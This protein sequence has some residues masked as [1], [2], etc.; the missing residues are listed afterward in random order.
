M[1]NRT[2]L[3][4]ISAVIIMITTTIFAQNAPIDFEAGGYGAN[5]TWAVFE[6]ATNPPLQIIANP[7]PTG[8]NTSATVAQFTAMQTGQPWAGTESQHGADIGM[9]NLDATNCTITIMVWKPVISDVGIKL[10]KPDSWALPEIKVSNTVTNAWE[11]LTFDFTSHIESGYDQIVVF[12]DFNLDGRTQD[13]VCYFDNITFSPQGDPPAGPAT[14]APTPT[15]NAND[16]I[17]LFSNAYT[18]VPVDTWSAEWD[19]ANVSDVQIDGD[20]VKL[21]TGLTFA[22]IEFTSS[23]I[24]ASGMS[25]FHMDFWT[26]DPT[27]APAIFKI[28]L[29]D[30]GADGVWGNDDVEHEIE[31]DETTLATE[32]WVSFNIPLTDFTGLTTTSH[33]AQ[34]IISGDPNTVY[35]DNVFFFDGEVGIDEQVNMPIGS[36]SNN[37]PNPFNPLTNISF[38]ITE[39]GQVLLEVYNLKGQWV[40]TLVNS[41]KTANTY[42]VSW[43][44][45]TATSGVYFY[46][47]S[48]NDRVIDTKKMI[49]LK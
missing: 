40:D 33:I 42:N 2:K 24:D 43:N 12:P 3:L 36:L 18:N 6:N 22:G 21:Y 32:S 14:P 23:T 39:P 48:L 8:A 13:N 19:N 17:S 29:V 5:W 46:R 1:N 47:L 35:I 49:L 27:A 20:D 34:L 25:Y 45:D 37:Y 4:I 9:F 7:D 38:S 16:V 31:F 41:H 15:Y 30:F 44:A 28:K 26:P 11:E 10:V